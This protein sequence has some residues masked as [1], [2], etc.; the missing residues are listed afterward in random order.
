MIR[1]SSEN[2][3]A[4][5]TR[6]KDHFPIGFDHGLSDEGLS[7]GATAFVFISFMEGVNAKKCA[8]ELVRMNG[9]EEN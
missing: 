7:A 1:A 4:Y 5:L 6:V 8:D 2:F 9:V 3:G